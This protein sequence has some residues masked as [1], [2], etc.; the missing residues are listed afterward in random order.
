[1][2]KRLLAQQVPL[3]AAFN[4]LERCLP[5]RVSRLSE[6]VEL[7]RGPRRPYHRRFLAASVATAPSSLLPR[8]S[9]AQPV[10]TQDSQFWRS[11]SRFSNDQR[12]TIK[13]TMQRSNLIYASLMLS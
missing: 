1:M 2:L 12:S 8:K 7:C 9:E 3:I 4:A 13:F 10:N 5:L 11:G 6:Y